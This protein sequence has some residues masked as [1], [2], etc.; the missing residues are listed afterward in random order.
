MKKFSIPLGIEQIASR[1]PGKLIMRQ[2]TPLDNVSELNSANANSVCFYENEKYLADL[3]VSQAGL[4][5]VP[6]DFDPQLKRNS[7][8]I[9]CEKPYVMFMLMVKE[10]LELTA[11]KTPPGIANTAH[12]ADTAIVHDTAVI[13]ENVNIAA[14]TRIGEHTVIEANTVIK[15]NVIIGKNCHLYPNVTIYEDCV[16]GDRVTLHAGVVIGSDG[17]GYIQHEEQQKKI[18]QVGNVVIEDDVEIGA[19]SCV[20]RATIGSTIVGR[21]TK[22]DNLVQVGHNC[23][24]GNN[25]ILCA[26]VGLAGSTEIGDLVYLA[27]QVGVAGHLK[28][29][30]KAMVGAQSGVS[31]SLPADEKYFGSPAREASRAKRIVAA[32]SMLP[33][34]LKNLR[35]KT[36]K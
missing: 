17:F 22:I 5:F 15:D 27:G 32:E 1:I 9:L 33:E 12:I 6:I 20:D 34:L 28:I 24:I 10:W 8:L 31:K 23:V 29:G 11:P 30:N 25:S 19:N 3:Q 13:G 21:G 35:K 14:S 26:Q 7:N 4:I 16:I 18:P 2:K 36:D